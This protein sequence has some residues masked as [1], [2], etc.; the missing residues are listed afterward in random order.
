MIS[1]DPDRFADTGDPDSI[2][3]PLQELHPSARKVWTIK[4][5]LVLSVL[6]FAA[7]I[8]DATMFFSDDRG[9]PPGA[10]SLAALIVAVALA[11][12]LPRLWYRFWRYSLRGEELFLRRGIFNRVSTIVPLRRIQH[13]DVSQ[14]I[15]ERE[16]ELG[17][18]IV[19]T[20]GTRS[21]DVVLP[22]L[23]FSEAERLRDELKN[24]ILE[25]TI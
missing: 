14:D 15:I 10:A 8:Y 3:P 4:T 18:L 21:S 12:T 7:L 13:L 1:H 9:L 16:F 6:V 24:F 17:K 25:D 22:G 5:L 2:D 19:H 11:F 23:A 20:A